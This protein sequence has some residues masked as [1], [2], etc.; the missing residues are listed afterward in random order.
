M[1]LAA[2]AGIDSKIKPAKAKYRMIPT[3]SLFHTGAI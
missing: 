1:V 2:W 3:S